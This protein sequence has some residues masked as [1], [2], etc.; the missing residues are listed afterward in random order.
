MKS[1][2]VRDPARVAGYPEQIK[3]PRRTAYGN[4]R[5]KL[6]DIIVIAFTAVLC[7]YEDYR[8]YGGIREAEAGFIQRVLELPGGYRMS[9]V[10]A[11]IKVSEP[12]GITERTGKPACGHKNTD[13][14]G[15]RNGAAGQ[16]RR[17]NDT[18]ERIS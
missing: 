4:I 18:R 5:H 14:R 12:A 7:G 1:I 15:G 13:E 16:Y 11:G 2:S 6:A 9:R 10:S 17:K 8:E 3:D